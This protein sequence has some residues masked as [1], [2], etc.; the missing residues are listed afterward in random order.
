MWQVT[1]FGASL[2]RPHQ[3]SC[4]PSS[5]AAILDRRRRTFNFWS[6]LI[7]LRSAF[8][9]CTAWLAARIICLH[10]TLLVLPACACTLACL[11]PRIWAACMGRTRSCQ[12]AGQASMTCIVQGTT[13][14]RVHAEMIAW[15]SGHASSTCSCTWNSVYS[16]EYL[17]ACRRLRRDITMYWLTCTARTH[18]QDKVVLSMRARCAHEPIHSYISPS[19]PYT[20]PTPLHNVP[21]LV[22][23]V[24]VAQ[25]HQGP[26][27]GVD[28]CSSLCV[29][30]ARLCACHVCLLYWK[31][32]LRFMYMYMNFT[33]LNID[34]W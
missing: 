13:P 16:A 33:A 30:T 26:W 8:A 21:L 17:L 25:Q 23:W 7:S 10:V 6:P 22:E 19:P 2:S 31:Y 29:A 14:G 28:A 24:I 27:E 18:A 1:I 12:S 20:I 3:T 15:G 34:A 32:R 9:L 4:W 5:L 11:V